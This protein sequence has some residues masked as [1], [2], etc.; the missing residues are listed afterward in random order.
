MSEKKIDESILDEVRLLREG[1]NLWNEAYYVRDKPIVPD[2][3]YDRHLRRLQVLE[4]EYPE[5][6]TPDSPTQRVGAEPM[7]EFGTLTHT[8][9]MLSLGNAFGAEDLTAFDR[10]VKER[11]IEA[12]IIKDGDEVAYVVE[13]KMD[14]LAV[15]LVYEDGIFVRGSTRGDGVTGEDITHNLKTIRSIP[16]RLALNMVIPKLLE[17]RGEV[18]IPLSSFEELN[19][20]RTADG[21]PPFANPR[22]AAAGSLRQ[23]DPRI[24]AER[25][26]DI[27]CYGIGVVDFADKGNEPETHS[28]ALRVLYE[29]YGIKV[30]PLC[31]LFEG[32]N[33]VIKYV[34]EIELKRGGLPYEIDGAVIKVDSYEA[35]QA[36]GELSRSPRWAVAYKFAAKEELTVVEDITVGVGRSGAL[37]PVALLKA[38]NVGGVVVRHATLHNMGEL[39]RKG[40]LIGDTVVVRRAGDVIP[41]VVSVIA[42]RRP[43]GA[44]PFIMPDNCPECGSPVEVKGAGH[45]CTGGLRCP[46]Q[47]KEGIGHFVSKGGMDIDGLGSKQVAQFVDEGL[48][49]DASDIYSLTREK[50]LALERFGEK[51]VENLLASIERSK[52]RPLAKLLFALGIGGVG[53]SMALT[54]SK[55]FSSLKDLER[56]T[57]EEL[58]EIDGLGP[59]IAGS[60]LDYFG[61][62]FNIELLKKLKAGGVKCLL[63]EKGG[64]TEGGVGEGRL[65]SGVSG[66][67]FLFTGTLGGISRSEAS[68]MVEEAGGTVVS[69]ISKKVDYLVVGTGGGGKE[70]KAKELGLEIISEGEFFK[71]LGR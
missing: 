2:A 30:N 44:T 53:S 5:L 6:V 67:R 69:G 17:V 25:P 59:E 42:E 55:T 34:G 21:D 35:Q 23:L 48:V 9:P 14:G 65:L 29:E 12:G 57:Y 13:P 28:E 16:L 10:R 33:E 63:G 24:T 36:L 58:V 1:L 31:R 61:D 50:L 43:D 71:L 46:A 70:A 37:T 32:L 11:L 60:I 8:I 49:S 62:D 41:E 18:F 45:F 64:G 22:N 56:A 27:Y 39:T 66:K 20:R 4:D 51:S 40:V 52:E 68:A 15:E 26:L 47:L 19:K 54:L 38:V 7:K 3:E